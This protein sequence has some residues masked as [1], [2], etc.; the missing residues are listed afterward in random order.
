VI[1]KSPHKSAVAEP[2]AIREATSNAASSHVSKQPK[3]A[4]TKAA[5]RGEARSATKK[6]TA[7]NTADRPSGM[8]EAPIVSPAQGHAARASLRSAARRQGCNNLRPTV[9]AAPANDR[10]VFIAVY[11]GGFCA[12]AI[13]SMQ[14]SY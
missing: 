7:V 13:F 8:N 14:S 9:M 10:R 6:A 3:K 5:A 4:P 11:R 12:K 2:D 1:K